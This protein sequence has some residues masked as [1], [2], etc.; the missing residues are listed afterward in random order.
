MGKP[1]LLPARLSVSP[2]S[3]KC[4]SSSVYSSF[5]SFTQFSLPPPP[6]RQA[7]FR[8]HWSTSDQILFF[9]SLFWMGLTSPSQALG[10]SLLPRT[11]RKLLTLSGI[12]LSAINL[13]R[14]VS[15]LAL[16]RGLD[17]FFLTGA[18]AWTPKIAP[19][20]VAPFESAKMFHMDQFLALF[21]PMIS[22][23]L[24]ASVSCSLC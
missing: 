16:F 11:S 20:E 19:N 23:S 18:L 22:L 1:H 21:S 3:Q 5:W 15:L 8:P 2:V 4:L 24:P 13:F 12:P 10:Q 17:L 6:S 7:S 9:L 14:L